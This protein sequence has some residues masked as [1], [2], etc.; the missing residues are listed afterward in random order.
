MALVVAASGKGAMADIP[1]AVRVDTVTEPRRLEDALRAFVAEATPRPREITRGTARIGRTSS[2]R[3]ALAGGCTRLDVVVGTPT[4]G[5]RARVWA[6]NGA[7]RGEGSGEGHVVLFACGDDKD[8]RFEV[9]ADVHEGPFVALAR[10]VAAVGAGETARL[11]LQTDPFR[12]AQ[13]WSHLGAALRSSGGTHRWR[14]SRTARLPSL[15]D[16]DAQQ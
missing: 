12:A 11:L 3:L 13:A 16:W 1:R 8:A 4:V 9:V 2:T 14:G 15:R 10:P 7:L 6:A 5:A